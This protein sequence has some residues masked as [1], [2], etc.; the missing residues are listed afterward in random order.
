MKLNR[1]PAPHIRF[2]ENNRTLMSDVLLLLLVLCVPAYLFYG[3]RVL[4]ICGVS[5]GCAVATDIICV[6]LRGKRVNLRDFSPVVTGMIIALAMPATVGY[7]VV[8]AAALF[9]ILVVKQPFGGVG[10]NVFNP[11]A[12][13]F[14]FAAVCWPEQVFMYPRPFATIPVFGDVSVRLFQNPSFVLKVGGIPTND[15]SEMVLGNYPGP[16]GATNILVLVACLVYLLFRRTIRWQ[17]PFSFLASCA[18]VA[19]LFPRVGTNGLQSLLFEMMSGILLFGAVFIVTDP[20]TSPK[21][22]SS[23]AAYGI[24]AGTITMLFRYFGG[25]EESMPFAVLFANAFVPVIDRYNE[26][27]HRLIRRKN[28]ETR[29]VKKAQK[30]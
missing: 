25:F 28:L 1:Y 20:V 13:G 9:A 4:V 6:L 23:L 15:I 7:R 18:F 24:F 19:F 3:P 26:S 21:R 10:N 29:K 22:D 2:Q 5:V 27:L 14:S 11:A 12:A 8:A 17:L 30:A 16:M